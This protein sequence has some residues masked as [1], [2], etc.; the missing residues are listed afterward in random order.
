MRFLHLSLAAALLTGLAA[1]SPADEQ[2]GKDQPK[3]VSEADI[4]RLV[5]DLGAEE[6]TKRKAAR[7]KLE[8]IGEPALGILKK[9]AE[10]ADDAEIRAAAKVLVEA[11]EAKF[12]GVVRVF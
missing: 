9:A 10:S 8:E 7:N 2:A 4:E 5:K 12:S 6:F 1:L 3:K 11:M